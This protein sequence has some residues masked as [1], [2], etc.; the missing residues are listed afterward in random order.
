VTRTDWDGLSLTEV[1]E[2]PGVLWLH[3]Y[4]MR[5][6]VWEPLWRHLPGWRH[7]GIDLPWHG[8][9]R[10]LRPG[11]DLAMLADTVVTNAIAASVTHVVALSFGTVLATEMAVRHPDAFDSWALAAPALAGMPHEPAVE[12]RY[13]DLGALYAAEGAGTHMADLWMSVPPAIF[14]GVNDRPETQAWLRAVI[15]RHEWRELADADMRRLVTRTQGPVEFAAVR[16]PVH[17]VVGE[18]ELLTHRACARSIAAAA[19]AAVVHVM[20]GCGH[21]ALL[22]EPAAAAALLG[23]HLQAGVRR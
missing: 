15:D 5:A 13:R 7:L 4:T 10:D 8:A 17:L 12:Q 14:A 3:G 22:E 6:S 2:G 9:S 23:E 1:G 21:L 20:R 19:P 11:E 18:R 16:V